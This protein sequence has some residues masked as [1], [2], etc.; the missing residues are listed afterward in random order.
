MTIEQPDEYEPTEPNHEPFPAYIQCQ[1]PPPL[2]RTLQPK[3]LETVTLM[4]RACL[5]RL[6]ATL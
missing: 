3:R 1:R 2:G 4:L 5:D 6:K